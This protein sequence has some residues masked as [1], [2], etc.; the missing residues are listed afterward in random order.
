MGLDIAA[1]LSRLILKP[2]HRCVEGVANRDIDVFMAMVGGLGPV[3]DHVL[4]R[5]ADIDPHGVELAFMMV[6]VGRLDYDGAIDDAVVETFELRD[7]RANALL[8]GGGGVHIPEA[9]LQR[10]RHGERILRFRDQ[11][12]P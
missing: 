10:Y 7:F 3:D 12:W 2:P 4:P 11:I 9:D 5:H 6:A 1:H 8:D